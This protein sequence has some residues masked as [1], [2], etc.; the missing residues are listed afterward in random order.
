MKTLLN[1]A[2]DRGYNKSL[3]FRSRKF[4][5]LN[6]PVE[7][8]YLNQEELN[9]MYTL[10]LREKPTLER[11]RDLFIIGC[12]TGLRYSD[13]TK[14]QPEN[15]IKE[16][17]STYI[18]IMTQKTS[19]RVVIPVNPKLQEILNKYDGFI[20]KP[21]TNQ[22]MNKYLKIIGLMAEIDKYIIITRIQADIKKKIK[23]AKYQLIKTHTARKS[24]A[25]NAFLSGVPTLSIMKITGHLTEGQFLK[26]VRITQ[27]ENAVSLSNHKFFNTKCNNSFLFLF[28]FLLS[29]S[30]LKMTCFFL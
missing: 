29:R 3:E 17:D 16:K 2:T 19:I 26:Y 9:K 18:N 21:L 24:F 28:S 11:V 12:Y 4:K 23:I 27:E 7:S 30:S 20:P 1:E 13:F 5:R 8:I 22:K 6:E 25:T 10:D 14:I 15:I